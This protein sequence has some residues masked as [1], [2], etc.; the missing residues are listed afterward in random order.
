MF[1]PTV[2]EVY[3]GGRGHWHVAHFANGEEGEDISIP[4]DPF[5]TAEAALAAADALNRGEILTVPQP[6]SPSPDPTQR[7]I[8]EARALDAAATKGPWKIFLSHGKHHILFATK[9]VTAIDVDQ[10]LAMEDATF[11]AR[12][13][14]LIPE[15]VA[16]LAG[17]QKRADNWHAVVRDICA[18]WSE[19]NGAVCDAKCDSYGHTGTCMATNIAEYLKSLRLQSHTAHAAVQ[20]AVDAT[21]TTQYRSPEYPSLGSCKL[22]IVPDHWP[23]ASRVRVTLVDQEG[24]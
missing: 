14:T 24:K 11:I 10:D 5:K 21:V 19:S 4:G 17:E 16:A 18:E 9:R 2:Q 22:V 15:L 1:S 7:L 23:L 12:A 13:R 3:N 6:P 8:A 20:A